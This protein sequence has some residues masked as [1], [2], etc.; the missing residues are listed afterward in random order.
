MKEAKAKQYSGSGQAE[1]EE[2]DVDLGFLYSN[3]FDPNT[4]SPDEFNQLVESTM[5]VISDI[6]SMNFE[7]EDLDQYLVRKVSARDD[8]KKAISMFWK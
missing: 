5:R 4:T 8:S 1:D 7:K 2:E 3:L 6:V